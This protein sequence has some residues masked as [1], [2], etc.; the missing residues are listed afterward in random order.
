MAYNKSRINESYWIINRD[1]D[2]IYQNTNRQNRQSINRIRKN[3]M[4]IYAAFRDLQ[5]ENLKLAEKNNERRLNYE[6]E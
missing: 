5:K 1:C 6:C 4:S 3:L 2:F